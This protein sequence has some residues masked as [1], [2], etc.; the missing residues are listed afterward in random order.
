MDTISS[1]SSSSS[2][3]N[4]TILEYY[5]KLPKILRKQLKSLEPSFQY[6]HDVTP[7]ARDLQRRYGNDMRNNPKIRNIALRIA[8]LKVISPIYLLTKKWFP[9]VCVYDNESDNTITLKKLIKME[10]NVAVLKGIT[11]GGMSVIVKWFGSPKRTT[12]YELNVYKKLQ[13]MKCPLPEFCLTCYF[14]NTRVLVMEVLEPLEDYDDEFRMGREVLDQLR[15]LHKFAVHNGLKPDNVMKK[16]IDGIY[17]YFLIDYGGVAQEKFRYGYKRWLWSPHWTCQP[18]RTPNQVT[19]PKHDFIELG[20]TMK[21]I[22]NL[23]TGKDDVRSHYKGKLKDYM[24]AVESM[25]ARRIKDSDYDS[26]ISILS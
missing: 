4:M 13:K 25:D 20:Y 17:Q 1:S 9:Y 16:K 5:K 3:K 14:W 2:S 19:T 11:N 26:L 8:M 21:A 7:V 10:D 24:Y 18:K 22:Q 12:E 6:D 23:R 15:Y